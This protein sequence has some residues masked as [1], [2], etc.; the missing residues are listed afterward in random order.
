MV[1]IVIAPF[2]RE[3]LQQAPDL[4]DCEREFPDAE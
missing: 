4:Q 2:M 1:N 3:N